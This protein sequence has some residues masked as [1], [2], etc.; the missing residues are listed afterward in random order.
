M[1]YTN[2]CLA[3]GSFATLLEGNVDALRADNGTVSAA[4][5]SF[6]TLNVPS[7]TIAAAISGLLMCFMW[8]HG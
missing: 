7:F 8:R 6:V 4:W 1:V 3:R 5:L 2:L